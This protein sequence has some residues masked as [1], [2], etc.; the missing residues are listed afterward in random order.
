MPGSKLMAR[1]GK[2]RSRG[3]MERHKDDPFRYGVLFTTVRQWLCFGVEHL[4]GHICGLGYAPPTAH[5][6]GKTD[7]DGL[8]PV[9]G[10]LHDLVEE[11][12]SQVER[13][14][15]EAGQPSLQEIGRT[16]LRQA[17]QALVDRGELPSEVEAVCRIKGIL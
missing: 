8:L 9:C 6:L 11:R 13:A 3:V 17:S 14:L 15:R 2:L 1:P 12:P 5:H 10:R 16:Y 4:P 7:L